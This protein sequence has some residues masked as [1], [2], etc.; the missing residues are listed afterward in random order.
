M[1][2]NE[3]YL[4]YMDKVSARQRCTLRDAQTSLFIQA[5]EDEVWK[6][7][8][9]GGIIQKTG[10]K[11]RKCDFLIYSER[12]KQTHLIELKGAAIRAAFEQIERTVLA[13]DKDEDLFFLVQKQRKTDAYLVSPGRQEV[14]K[15]I[16]SQK[17]RLGTMLARY[18]SEKVEDVMELVHRVRVVSKSNM[19]Q[20]NSGVIL[21]S[22]DQ[23]IIF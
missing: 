22:N 16:N 4:N 13:L 23:P 12:K 20:D 21:N 6:V 1:K 9:D 10:E 5:G 15:N 8:V 2:I 11:D 18:S 14:P 3:K 17:R 19:R 7:R